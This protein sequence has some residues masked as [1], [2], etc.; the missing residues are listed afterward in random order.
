MQ[1]MENKNLDKLRKAVSAKAP[2]LSE[3][4]ILSG[5]A[6]P[7]PSKRNS[8][9]VGLSTATVAAAALFAVFPINSGPLF[10]VGQGQGSSEGLQASADAKMMMWI[11]YEYVAGPNLSNDGGS[12]QVY[13]LNLKG[14]PEQL[15]ESLATRFGVEGELSKETWDEGKTYNYFFGIKDNYEKA[16]VNLYWSGTGNWYFGDYSKY[17][18]KLNLPSEASA[19]EAAKEI[20][21]ATGL[22]VAS[23]AI[24]INKGD[25][26][27]MATANLQVNGQD[28]A[29]EWNVTWAPNGEIVSASGHSI[30]VEAKGTYGTVSPK[31]A[32]DRLGDWRYGG[33]AASS[34]FGGVMATMS[35]DLASSNQEGEAGSEPGTE[36][37]VEPTEEPAVEPTEE[38]TVEPTVEPTEE[39][40]VEPTVEPSIEPTPEKVTMTLLSSQKTHLL[41]WDSKGGAW[42]VPGYMLKNQDGWFSAVMSLVDG[43]IALPKL[44][45]G[46]MPMTKEG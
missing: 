27:M 2:T 29:V 46:V 30:S 40:A 45:E 38:P 22:D 19:K 16:N 8:W 32:V 6:K 35:R 25:W 24:S 37:T 13:R 39:P 23:D 44:D 12:D 34:Y 10:E 20:F 15:I 18:E 7:R 1:D 28:T 26:G 4:T 31:A 14:S 9:L 11:D 3:D 43:I 17:A 42:L 36:P 21:G 5:I 41:I 33:S